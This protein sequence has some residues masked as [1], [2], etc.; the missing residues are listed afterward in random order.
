M[1]NLYKNNK[2]VLVFLFRAFCIYLGWMLFYYGW[3]YNHRG[4]DDLIIRHL[5]W[6]CSFVLEKSGFDSFYGFRTIG[7]RGSQGLIV[8]PVCDGLSLFVLFSGFIVAFP[9][10]VRSKAVFIASGLVIID[11]LNCMRILALV[12]IFRFSP[13]SLEFNHSYT[14]TLIL[15]LAVFGMWIRWI[16]KSVPQKK[17]Q[18]E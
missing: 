14:F 10:N 16:R 15:Y 12:L 6:I 8:S 2:S 4:F 11:L 13:E 18:M 5:I 7:I 3:L 9:G 1:V 17:N